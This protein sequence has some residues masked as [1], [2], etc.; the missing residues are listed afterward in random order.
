MSNK[1]REQIDQYN[2]SEKSNK[3]VSIVVPIKGKHRRLLEMSQE[4]A[5]LGFLMRNSKKNLSKKN[6][7]FEALSEIQDAIGIGKY[8]KRIECYDINSL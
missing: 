5:K 6:S 3:K 2:N 8:L 7:S 4:N 1:E